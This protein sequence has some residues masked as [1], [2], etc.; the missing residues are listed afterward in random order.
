MI[1]LTAFPEVSLAD[2]P[3]KIRAWGLPPQ[4]LITLR[5]WLK[6]DKGNLFHSQAF[7]FTDVKGEVDLEHASATGGD[8]QGVL[9]MGLLWSLK[10]PTLLRLMKRDIMGS[11]FYV[12]LELYFNKVMFP[13]SNDVPVAVK[14]IERWYVAPGVQ[15]INVRDGRV[16]GALFLPKGEGPFP[17]VID[18]FGGSG[19]LIE[20][21][22]SL[23]ASHGFAVLSLAFF[24]YEDLPKTLDALDL[25]YFEEAAEYLLNNPKVSNDGV[26]V[27]G[28]SKGAEV[29]LA[30]ASY[31]PQVKATIWINGTNAVNGTTLTYG[32]LC[33]RGIPYESHKTVITST[34]AINMKQIYGDTRNPEYQDRLL[35]LEKAK[36]PILFLVGE[37]D[38]CCDSLKYANEALARA[39]KYGKINVR[40][41]SYPRAGH[42]IEPPGSPFCL[43]SPAAFSPAP[44][45]WG[46]E[47]ESHCYAQELSWK[48]MHD[49]LSVNIR[50][51]K[52]SK[53]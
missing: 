14:I 4:Q 12:H 52:H 1:G 15:R 23:L 13:S 8:F 45:M 26:G 21:R 29:A 49:F 38:Q 19:G 28:L 48:E 37:D 10:S 20:F 6:D 39:K 35:P 32:N 9:P 47:L 24:A 31:L 16:R 18:M 46:G 53:L 40:I 2:E 27:V 50:Q 3:V 22:S 43:V 30:M 51:S 44:F 17:G 5:A 41:S 33:I 25:E 7:Y 42:L 34:S 36:G 11:P